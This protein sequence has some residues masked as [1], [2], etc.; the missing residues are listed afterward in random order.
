M[1]MYNEIYNRQNEFEKYI[2]NIIENT[3]YGYTE[4]E[5]GEYNIQFLPNIGSSPVCKPVFK[6]L[7][8]EN[9]TISIQC[10]LFAL[11]GDVSKYNY[12][13]EEGDEF[14]SVGGFQKALFT[15]EFSY[16]FDL[17]EETRNI[18]LRWKNDY[19]YGY[20]MLECIENDYA[21]SKFKIK[22][23]IDKFLDN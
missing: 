12:D 1:S 19:T 14:E 15:F 3:D 17:E 13:D 18:S 4:F 22:P 21:F 23:L 5:I 16:N 20:E 11:T 8:L 10:E 7:I 6:E 9:N 2:Q